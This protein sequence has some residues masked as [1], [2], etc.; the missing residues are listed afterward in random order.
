[1]KIVTAAEMREIDRI[2]TEKYGLPSLTLM[3]N[4]GS[5]VAQFVVEQYPDAQQI[6]VVC[7]KGNNGGDGL[8]AARKLHEGGKQVSVLLL[9]NPAELKGDAAEMLKRLPNPPVVVREPGELGRNLDRI[10]RSDLMID[11]ILGTGFRPPVSELYRTAIDYLRSAGAPVVAVDIPS[12]VESDATNVQ[13]PPWAEAVVTFTAPKPAHVFASIAKGAMVLAPIGSPE[14]AIQSSMGIE[15]L[16]PR[17]LKVLRGRRPAN[18]N[19]GDFGHVLIFGG[20]LGKSGA[21]AMAGMASLKVGA[22]LAT[23]ATPRSALPAVAAFTPELM[24][25]PLEETEAGTASGAA[26]TNLLPLVKRKTVVAIGPGLSQHSATVWAVREFVRACTLPIVLDAD[27]L[28]AFEESSDDLNGSMRPLIITPHPGEMARL[29]K[30]TT[31]QVQERR[32]DIAREFATRHHAVVVLKGHR[33]VITEPGGKVWVNMTGNPGMA[34]GGTGD[35]LTG[36]IAGMI[37]QHPTSLIDAVLAA[38]YLHGLA[39]DLAV[40]K[41]GE[42]SLMATDLVSFL[43]DAFRWVSQQAVETVTTLRLASSHS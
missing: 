11:A 10:G 15:V 7:G 39:G 3:E 24:T 8:V 33:T 6:T 9:A 41:T 22:G 42:R 29:T 5:A 21:A 35:V 36:M 28:N 12:G 30:L 17:E 37:A 25:E 4:A 43:P 18:A 20:S 27:G 38:V 40:Q 16:T 19:K 34:K 1:M 26:L 2:T 14:E 13:E 32:I 31:A 23:V